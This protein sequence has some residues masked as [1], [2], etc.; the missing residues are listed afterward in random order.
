MGI[1]A[2]NFKNSV[3]ISI[4][5]MGIDF[6]GEQLGVKWLIGKECTQNSTT[7]R[8]AIGR[9][10]SDRS[11]PSG[12]RGRQGTPLLSGVLCMCR[13]FEMLILRARAS[14]APQKSISILHNTTGARELCAQ[15]HVGVQSTRPAR[16]R[17]T[18]PAPL[19]GT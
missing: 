9:R 11:S 2:G 3:E 5:F 8:S 6:W 15:T 4:G 12:C 17:W 16:R 7:S 18:K 14:R 10:V 13:R 1:C 19:L